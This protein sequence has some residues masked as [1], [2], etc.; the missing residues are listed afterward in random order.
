VFGF[1]LTEALCSSA[2]FL[3]FSVHLIVCVLSHINIYKKAF[4]CGDVIF[5]LREKKN[6]AKRKLAL[7]YLHPA[8][9]GSKRACATRYAQTV[10]GVTACHRHCSAIMKGYKTIE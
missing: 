9:F 4:A 10:L 1:D 3:G 2:F 5:L 6:E 7:H 8:L